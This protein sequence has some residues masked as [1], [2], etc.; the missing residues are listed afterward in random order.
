MKD[1]NGTPPAAEFGQLRAFLAQAGV[2]QAQ[3]TEWIGGSPAGRTRTEIADL[4]RAGLR[5]LPK[6]ATK[7][8]QVKR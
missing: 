2:S 1:K 6:A 4:L 3:I 7:D 5:E 8:K